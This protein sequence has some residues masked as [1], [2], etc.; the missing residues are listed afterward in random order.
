MWLCYTPNVVQFTFVDSPIFLIF[1]FFNP[2]PLDA[3]IPD[4]GPTLHSVS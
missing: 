3:D 4:A 1:F 2:P